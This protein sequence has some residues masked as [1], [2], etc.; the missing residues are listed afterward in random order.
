MSRIT[1]DLDEQE[2][3]TLLIMVG[4]AMGVLNEQGKAAFNWR[5]CI[6]RVYLAEKSEAGK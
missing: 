3:H 5:S 2:Y 6:E 1:I 4:I